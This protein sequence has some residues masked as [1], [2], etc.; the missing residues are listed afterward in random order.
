MDPILCV[1][2]VFFNHQGAQ[3]EK[4]QKIPMH[5]GSLFC[6]WTC[7]IFGSIPEDMIQIDYTLKI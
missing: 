5:D 4:K 2:D 3:T 7:L 6:G 1:W